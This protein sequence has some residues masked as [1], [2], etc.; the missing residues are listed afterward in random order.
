[1]EGGCH[2]SAKTNVLWK[3]RAAAIILMSREHQDVFFSSR[4]VT[5]W[6]VALLLILND[7]LRKNLI[8]RFVT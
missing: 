5:L 8:T 6:D 7:P 2:S 1:V 4:E 3:G